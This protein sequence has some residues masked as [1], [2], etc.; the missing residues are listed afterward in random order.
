MSTS[1][2][3]RTYSRDVLETAVIRAVDQRQSIPAYDEIHDLQLTRDDI[4]LNPGHIVELISQ[5]NILSSADLTTSGK[6]N[7]Q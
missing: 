4:Y 1:E 2:N 6:K 7:S 5:P 3:S